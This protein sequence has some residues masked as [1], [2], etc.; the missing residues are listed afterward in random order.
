MLYYINYK[1]S[2]PILQDIIKILFM[3]KERKVSKDGSPYVTDEIFNTASHIFGTILSITVTVL[4]VV[5]ASV[6]GKVWHI[7]S[8]S[9]YGVTLVS[10]FLSSSFHHGI[11]G[12][13]KVENIFRLFDYLAIFLLIAGTYTPIC[14]T[15]LRGALGWSI[16]GIVWGLA[17]I[18]ILIKI[19]F[20][21]IPKWVTN[22]IYISMG[23]VGIVMI[24]RLYT[25]IGIKGVIMILL[26]GLFYTIGSFI[27]Y[28]EKP[29]PIPNKFGFHE[30]WHIFVIMGA[31]TFSLFMYICILPN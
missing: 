4:L 5:F 14:L 16:F 21:K 20:Q 6:A 11:D 8:F 13:K 25:S 22:T 23:W 31:L 28:L 27:F 2:L 18:G 17:I 30:I 15:V 12:N 26:A 3:K 9:I 29:N 7:V 24:Y 1:I 10:V 19:F